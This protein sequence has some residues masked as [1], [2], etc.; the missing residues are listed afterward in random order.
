[1]LRVRTLCLAGF[2]CAAF[3]APTA[4][5]TP[6]GPGVE[7]LLEANLTVLGQ[8]FEYPEGPGTLTAAIVTV[9][10]G[11]VLAPHL[12]PVPVFGYILRGAL[13]VDY[14]SRGEIAYGRGDAFV[15]AFDW[16]HQGRNG[17]RGVVEILVVYAGSD[18]VPNTVPAELK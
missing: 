17:G 13:V 2:V 11:A 5:A 14:G 6:P 15:E 4:V 7:T 16:P 3:P 8:E 9:P 10:P 1:M 18:G 12:H